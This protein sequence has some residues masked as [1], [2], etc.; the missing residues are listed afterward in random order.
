MHAAWMEDKDEVRKV[1]ATE[2]LG[3]GQAMGK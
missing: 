3:R 2:Q 1:V